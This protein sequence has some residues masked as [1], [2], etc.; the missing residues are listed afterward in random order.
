MEPAEFCPEFD[1]GRPVYG[2][3]LP[4]DRVT[5]HGCAWMIE[6]PAARHRERFPGGVAR[7]SIQA[8]QAEQPSRRIA[9][10]ARQAWRFVPVSG[11]SSLEGS[12]CPSIPG[13][14]GRFEAPLPEAS[15]APSGR[16]VPGDPSPHCLQKGFSLH[17]RWS[18]CVLLGRAGGK[19]TPANSP[20][21]QDPF[22]SPRRATGTSP[23]NRLRKRIRPF[24]PDCTGS[25]VPGPDPAD[26]FQSPPHC[27][28]G[29]SDGMAPGCLRH[30]GSGRGASRLK[31]RAKA[32][33]GKPRSAS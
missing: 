10:S 23:C 5:W 20:V 6:E 12:G 8:S 1:P 30:T 17:G 27:A 2:K 21:A 26:P 7:C 3:R 14:A 32:A 9:A 18:A 13:A 11:S 4:H 25:R 24:F 16:R 31:R 33:A 19:G 22:R 28:P 15:I 29:W